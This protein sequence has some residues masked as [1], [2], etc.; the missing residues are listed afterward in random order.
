MPRR[1][2]LPELLIVALL[3]LLTVPARAEVSGAVDGRALF[4]LDGRYGGA[5]MLD[6]WALRGRWRPGGCF[7]LGALSSDDD[8]SA[9]LFSPLGLSLSFV[10]WPERSSPFLTGRVGAYFGAEKGGFL[11]GFYTGGALGYGLHVGEGATVRFAADV[12]AMVGER[13][14]FFLGPSLGLGF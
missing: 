2:R 9:R 5:L 13:G 6:A 10:P 14:G 8:S 1:P 3:A 7:G 12:W 11:V 4:G